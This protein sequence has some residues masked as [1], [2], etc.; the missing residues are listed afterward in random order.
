[1][2]KPIFN[3]KD[4]TKEEII[5][6]FRKQF[7]D[8]IPNSSFIYDF[9]QHA[10]KSK[11]INNFLALQELNIL[12]QD[13]NITTYDFVLGVAKYDNNKEFFSLYKDLGIL[14][15]E[16]IIKDLTRS[17]CIISTLLSQNKKDTLNNLL[18]SGYPKKIFNNS[19]Y[20]YYIL[21]NKDENAA[22]Y[23][24]NN[25]IK[26]PFSLIISAFMWSGSNSKNIQKYYNIIETFLDHKL[27]DKEINNIQLNQLKTTAYLSLLHCETLN[28]DLLD[29]FLDKYKPGVY[30]SFYFEFM[31][32]EKSLSK[33]IAESEETLNYFL[34]NDISNFSNSD[35]KKISHLVGYH[36]LK[37]NSEHNFY[38]I[39]EK[40]MNFN[41]KDFLKSEDI[42]LKYLVK[43]AFIQ[44]KNN[45][46]SL[47]I[48]NGLSLDYSEQKDL[49]KQTFNYFSYMYRHSNGKKISKSHEPFIINHIIEDPSFDI[50][51]SN[52]NIE[53]SFKERDFQINFLQLAL[54][55]KNTNIL[56]SLKNQERFD[57]MYSLTEFIFNKVNEYKLKGIKNPNDI[58]D[59]YSDELIKNIN[60]VSRIYKIDI[61]D[62]IINNIPN[63]FYSNICKEDFNDLL[64]VSTDR[65]DLNAILKT[66]RQVTAFKKGRL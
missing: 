50:N 1:M 16:Y 25:N 62:T 64:K 18:N 36:A 57:V 34:K 23:L 59:E 3:K 35:L 22:K 52:I 27:N 7:G 14:N 65:N 46:Y 17:N 8:I 31:N 21:Q 56:N 6:E 53:I 38:N 26:I 58:L 63:V 9:Y 15:E 20:L 66:K 10:I 19:S 11:N 4:L 41:I 47:L 40:S 48:K 61:K 29:T 5:D 55:S 44:H 32:K 51:S 28:K 2:K 49:F 33:K 30:D 54:E 13:C 60:F 12:P 24:C 45:T 42:D 39:L 37:N 43:D